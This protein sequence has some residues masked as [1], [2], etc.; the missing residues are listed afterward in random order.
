[1]GSRCLAMKSSTRGVLVLVLLVTNVR[2][3][4]ASDDQVSNYVDPGDQGYYTGQ[5]Q[6]ASAPGVYPQY[7][8]APL[9]QA[10]GQLSDT[11]RQAEL[12][13]PVIDAAFSP[14]ML[15]A[16]FVA[17]ALGGMVAPI[18]HGVMRHVANIPLPELPNLPR[19]RRKDDKYRY[20]DRMLEAGMDAINEAIEETSDDA[21]YYQ[22][23]SQ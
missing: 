13:T 19:I 17:A 21:E 12:V 2:G 20:Q 3:Q 4:V 9:D 11:D 5:Y 18:V 8:S 16:T 15:V 1:M 22:Y 6:A 10:T 14:I 23:K 7:P